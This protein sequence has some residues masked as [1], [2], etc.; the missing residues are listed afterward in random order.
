MQMG[1]NSRIL[2]A[3]SLTIPVIFLSGCTREATEANSREQKA[4][5]L[6]PSPLAKA[7]SIKGTPLGQ[8][9][10]NSGVAV[11]LLV[12]T[13]GIP[14]IRAIDVRTGETL[15]SD[16]VSASAAPRGVSINVPVIET[17]N[18]ALAAVYTAPAD[19]KDEHVHV[20]VADLRTGRQLHRTKAMY[21][22]G[23][24]RPCDD[25]KN[26]CFVGSYWGLGS[27]QRMRLLLTDDEKDGLGREMK[28]GETD[29]VY[30]FPAG[31]RELGSGVVDVGQRNPEKVA[32]LRGEALAWTLPVDEVFAPGSSSDGGWS[33][34]R[35]EKLRTSVISLGPAPFQGTRR[36]DTLL[37]TTAVDDRGK[38]LWRR[39]GEGAWCLDQ[40]SG[41][42]LGPPRSGVTFLCRGQ[43]TIS[44]HAEGDGTGS[45][46]EVTGTT[47]AAVD[48]STGRNVWSASLPGL[49]L[50]GAGSAQSSTV[51]AA[52]EGTSAMFVN[53]RDRKSVVIDLSSGATRAPGK[54][55][56]FYC[57]KNVRYG[58]PASREERSGG[59][60]L[61]AC[62]SENAPD[63]FGTDWDELP[64]PSSRALL[65]RVA[66]PVDGTWVI[67]EPQSLVGYRLK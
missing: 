32:L 10:V 48:I 56:T 7:W 51:V 1:K 36:I 28:A 16:T 26:V 2:L 47:L 63:L 25:G 31:G 59:K 52:G 44:H 23:F 6:Q 15:W 46:Y 43:G 11:A 58:D 34:V 24:P 41:S 60:V 37:S 17:G 53:V 21:V 33:V 67:A 40:E 20:V 66:D 4:A 12:G 8:P 50:L 65:D 9:T 18:G 64:S 30:A 13:S 22:T 62:T 3:V 42:P 54:G 35:D 19:T 38:V 27:A 14:E 45:G 29:A 39:P 61:V 49:D 57:R 55:E 5:K